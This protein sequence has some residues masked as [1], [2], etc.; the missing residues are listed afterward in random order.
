MDV[1]PQ[2]SR[3][4]PTPSISGLRPTHNAAHHSNPC[5]S[6]RLE[7]SL[8]ILEIP[9][10]CFKAIVLEM[11]VCSRRFSRVYCHCLR[12]LSILK[13]VSNA[14][15]TR[16]PSL[17]AR[18]PEFCNHGLLAL[19]VV[20]APLLQAYAQP[21]P[22]LQSRISAAIQAASNKTDLDYTEFVNPFIGTDT[23]NYGDVW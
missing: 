20:L 1:G 23:V 11:T 10:F 6:F 13:L 19:F 14:L 22:S 16:H 18:Y 12:H 3:I 17:G 2:G 5:F 7:A 8:M 9:F 21:S 4:M 15:K